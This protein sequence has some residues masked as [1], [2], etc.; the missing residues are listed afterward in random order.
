MQRIPQIASYVAAELLLG[1]LLSSCISTRTGADKPHVYPSTDD[2]VTIQPWNRPS[3]TFD[4]GTTS[5]FQ[6]SR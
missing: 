3:D 2:G 1:L 6:Q 4:G 5:G